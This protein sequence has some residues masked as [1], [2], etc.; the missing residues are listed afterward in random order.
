[1]KGEWRASAIRSARPV[2]HDS[3]KF[4][5]VVR[6]WFASM[7][8]NHGAAKEAER[9]FR[10][11]LHDPRLI[12]SNPASAAK[13]VAFRMSTPRLVATNVAPHGLAR[14]HQQAQICQ[15]LA[16]EKN[17]G[18]RCSHYLQSQFPAFTPPLSVPH[19]SDLVNG[20]HDRHLGIYLTKLQN[21]LGV[22]TKLLQVN[23][24]IVPFGIVIAAEPRADD[25]K[26]FK[27]SVPQIVARNVRHIRCLCT[28]TRRRQE[29]NCGR[30]REN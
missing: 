13:I 11:S 9:R 26:I 15:T 19:S 30:Y 4:L 3:A 14:H 12:A 21:P 23:N 7:I 20:L 10:F 2:E 16:E 8:V 18:I 1:L 25:H 28:S 24:C 5:E 6:A 22:E 17:R 29:Q 27:V